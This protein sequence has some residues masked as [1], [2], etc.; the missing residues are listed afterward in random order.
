[1]TFKVG[2]KIPKNSMLRRGT[3][4]I[5]IPRQKARLPEPPDNSMVPAMNAL[6]EGL[7]KQ[8]AERN[9]LPPSASTTPKPDDN[10]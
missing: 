2:Y 1:M 7:Q 9:R 10:T 4:L 3:L 5:G 6:E 8:I